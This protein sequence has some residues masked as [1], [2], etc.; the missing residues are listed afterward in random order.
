VDT[1]FTAVELELELELEL[2]D[3]DDDDDD[4]VPLMIR[5]RRL[6][7]SIVLMLES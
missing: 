6:F 2:D 5:L 1:R 7:Q 3:D 4:G